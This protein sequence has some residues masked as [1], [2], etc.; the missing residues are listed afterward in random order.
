MPSLHKGIREAYEILRDGKW[1]TSVEIKQRHSQGGGEALRRV[2]D[3]R[4]RLAPDFIV[5]K[6]RSTVGRVWMYRI[7]QVS[8]T[9]MQGDLFA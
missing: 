6:Q 8:P 5:E 9:N 1:H 7:K 4:P 3:L 2:R